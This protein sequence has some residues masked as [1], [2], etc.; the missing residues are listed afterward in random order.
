MDYFITTLNM[1]VLQFHSIIMILTVILH[2]FIAAGVARDIGV[3]NK[4]QLPPL[5]L[6]GSI[7][8]LA[9]LITGIWGLFVYWL[10]HHSSLA[11]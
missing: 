1:T 2:L 6:P 10:M 5:V 7:W 8:V 11:R 9:A 3:M 4:R